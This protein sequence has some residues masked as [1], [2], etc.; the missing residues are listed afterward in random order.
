MA[1]GES[2]QAVASSAAS[3]RF[4][5]GAN[6][7]L[8][9]ILAAVLLVAV[10][11]FASIKYLRKDVASF[12]NFGLSERTKNV[13]AAGDAP[14]EVSMVYMPDEENPRQQEYMDR[15]TDYLDEMR[16]YAPRVKVDPVLTD[17]QRE[18]LVARISTTFGSEADRHKVALEAF[19]ALSAELQ[20]DLRRNLAAAQALMADDRWL[21]A[22]PIFASV[23]Q[24]LREDAESLRKADESLKELAPVT[25]IPRYGDAVG[26]A[27][28]V[29]GEVKNHIKAVEDGLTR[30]AQLADEAS[31]PDSTYLAMLKQVAGETKSLIGSIRAAVGADGDP[32]PKDPAAA[33]KAFADRGVE[34][35]KSL[36]A[37]VRR[38]D[39]FAR[40]FPMV[41]QHADWAAQVQLGPLVTRMEVADV[42]L[43]AGQTLSK[44]RLVILGMIDAGDRAQLERALKDV[45]SNCAILEKNAEIC[46]ELLTALA[47][48][49]T[50]IDD[51]SRALLESARSKSLFPGRTEAIAELTGKFD[52][53]PELKLAAAADQ[54]KEPN[55][56]VIETGGKIR[57]LGFSEVWPVRESIAGPTARNEDVPRTF[58]GDSAISSAVLA[59]T[60]EKPFATVVLVAFEPPAPPQ[61]NQFM[62][63]PQQSW[64]PSSQLSELRK[65]LEA[66][67][68]KIVD[69][70]MATTPD[71]PAQ[72]PDTRSIYVCLPPPPPQPPNPFGQSQPPDQVFGE[73]QRKQI[74]DLLD[75][76]A[77]VL[78]L[79]TWEFRSGGM[80][81]GPPTTPPYGY[82]PLLESDWGI[83]VESDIRITWVDPDRSK[84]NSFFVVQRRFPH[85]PALGFTDHAIG[86]PLVGTR[87]LI[88]DTCPLALKSPPPEGVTHEPVL[89]IPNTQNYIG[90]S[91]GEL[92]QIIDMVNDPDRQGSITLVPP[93]P[94]GPFCTMA[95][96]RRTAE[97]KSRGR[98]LVIGFGSSVRDDYLSQPVI[99][100]GDQ[101]RL[102]PP[103]TENVDLMVNALYWLGDQAQFIAR[104]P[105]PVP[106]IAQIDS[107]ELRG[108][109]V[110]VWAVWPALVFAPGIVLWLVRRR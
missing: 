49:L 80:F 72:E 15:L 79:A 107:S 85:M 57:V 47:E 7:T 18:R 106:R 9:L 14:I 61:R 12:G 21:G 44:T 92:M 19:T 65:R 64:I 99:G 54:L 16:R 74:K 30:L 17:S 70:N 38:V 55:I 93:P 52:E 81:G 11:W 56:L 40:R 95:A 4:S 23:V 31:K 2:R 26:K 94:G 6:V 63:P 71:A 1:V 89:V 98:V 87:C 90:A 28:Q 36:E 24:T 60:R 46:D 96:A 101:L 8:A 50:K 97:G 88:T 84:D 53:L 69:W 78:F 32:M 105:V 10:N 59:M 13:L 62:P 37:I 108:L 22:F 76:D 41:T 83:T 5:I 34:V 29:L 66:A 91:I 48:D 104:G 67:N 68:F 43:Q 103:P 102:E 45:R 51:G 109:R 77:T 73:K 25:G 42:L 39:E 100:D 58:N 82:G 27:R 20:E 3:R 75:A 110:F 86:A 33:L 35:G